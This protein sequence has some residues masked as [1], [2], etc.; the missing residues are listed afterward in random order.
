MRWKFWK[1][2]Y[3]TTII[4]VNY[5]T[6]A[7]WFFYDSGID[8]PN[9]LSQV[10]GMLPTSAEGESMEENDSDRRLDKIESLYALLEII[11]EI[12]ALAISGLQFESMKE[13]GMIPEELLNS[14]QPHVEAVYKAI[15]FSALRTAFAAALELDL[16]ENKATR[17]LITHDL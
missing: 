8:D 11:A 3:N 16:I 13:D 4:D 6:L 2:K 15:G 5:T 1:P 7:R 17:G 12:N 10:M 9:K 14:E